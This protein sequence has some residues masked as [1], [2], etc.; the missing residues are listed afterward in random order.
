[1]RTRRRKGRQAAF[2]QSRMHASVAIAGLS[3]DGVDGPFRSFERT[4][5]AESN[6]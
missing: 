5:G 6:L 3:Q 2:A 1:M 4:P